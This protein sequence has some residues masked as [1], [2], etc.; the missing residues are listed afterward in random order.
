MK[1]LRQQVLRIGPHF[2]TVLVTGEP[3]TGK[4]LVART[5]HSMSSAAAGPFVVC[6]ATAMKNGLAKHK[7][8]DGTGDGVGSLVTRSAGGILF[9]DQVSDLPL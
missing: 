3:G 7:P 2:R 5:L 4:E 8:S 6:P 9:I 1:R